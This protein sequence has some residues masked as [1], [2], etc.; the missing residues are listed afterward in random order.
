MPDNTQNKPGEKLTELA[1]TY[2]NQNLLKN[3]QPVSNSDGY[4]ANHP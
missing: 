2:R 3:I 1:S 4:S